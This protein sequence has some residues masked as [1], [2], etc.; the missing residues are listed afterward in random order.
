MILFRVVQRALGAVQGGRLP[1]A[2]AD[3]RVRRLAPPHRLRVPPHRAH[4]RAGQV[5]GPQQ[6]RALQAQL[7]PVLAPPIVGES[8]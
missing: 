8:R 1:D 5:H 4:R 7:L 3:G 2:Q 6:D